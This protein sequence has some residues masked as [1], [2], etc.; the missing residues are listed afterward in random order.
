MTNTIG[1]GD[2]SYA[3]SSLASSPV[4]AAAGDASD[5]FIAPNGQ[6]VTVTVKSPV[7][8]KTFNAFPIVQGQ[9]SLV[10]FQQKL[11]TAGSGARLI[12]SK[13][14]YNFPAVDCVNPADPNYHAQYILIQSAHDLVLDGQGST[15]NVTS[16]CTGILIYGS[17]RVTIQ[18][19]FIDWPNMQTAAVGVVAGIGGNNVSGYTYNLRL[20]GTNSLAR[21]NRVT[22]WDIADNYFSLTAPTHDLGYTTPVTL[23]PNGA[24]TQNLLSGGVRF[25]IGEGV[26]VRYENGGAAVNKMSQ[27]LLGRP[28]NSGGIPPTG[29][30]EVSMNEE[31]P[32]H[33]SVDLP[34]GAGRL[35]VYD[36]MWN[37]RNLNQ[38]LV[39]LDAAGNLS[40]AGRTTKRHYA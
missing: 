32:V 10:Y 21:I 35:V 39:C 23:A 37:K 4:T 6:L 40:V 38:N 27:A 18:N 28:R 3:L 1:F 31:A 13:A 16:N 30:R 36:W 26:L 29:L 9:N 24:V 11:A 25:N 33:E 14:T 19:F 2:P 20:N 34:D 15:L 17:T 8:T 7:T 12:I 22:S 5:Q